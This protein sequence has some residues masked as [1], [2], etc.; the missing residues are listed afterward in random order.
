MP[1]IVGCLGVIFTANLMLV[2]VTTQNIYIVLFFFLCIFIFLFGSFYF[3]R[4]NDKMFANKVKDT[5]SIYINN[6]GIN[7]NQHF[8]ADDGE[9][10]IVIDEK[11]KKVTII[12]NTRENIDVL[13][14]LNGKYGYEHKTF[15]YKDILK[16]EILKDG[17]SVT[18]TSATSTLGGAI[19]GGMVG[20]Q[21]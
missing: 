4:K 21:V 12:Y 3:G 1:Y 7:S 15:D 14:A 19:L 6:L 11:N 10:A 17:K 16:S 2:S 8:I 5:L 9:S 13:S 18:S 20:V